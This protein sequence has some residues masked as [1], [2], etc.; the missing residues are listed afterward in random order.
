M[1][2]N[3]ELPAR[4]LNLRGLFVPVVLF[5]VIASWVLCANY[6]IGLI[7]HPARPVQEITVNNMNYS[8]TCIPT[9]DGPV[10]LNLYECEDQ[11]DDSC[12]RVGNTATMG[13]N[14]DDELILKEQNGVIEVVNPHGILEPILI[15]YEPPA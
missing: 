7:F 5:V 10:E 9:L 14:C 15:S 12:V 6:F 8:L 4:T 3:N 11:F 2:V 13:L 1:T